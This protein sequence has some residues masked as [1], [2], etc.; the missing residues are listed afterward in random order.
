MLK[1]TALFL[2]DGFPNDPTFRKAKCRILHVVCGR[3]REPPPS[4]YKISQY[5][6]SYFHPD[7]QDDEGVNSCE[8]EAAWQ[9]CALVT[10]SLCELAT[11][12]CSL[13]RSQFFKLG[14]KQS[15]D[16]LLP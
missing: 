14:C 6:G 13:A 4:P 9:H 7:L 10:L 2:H 1:K 12:T 15:I 5:H 11:S 8:K 16:R 3:Q